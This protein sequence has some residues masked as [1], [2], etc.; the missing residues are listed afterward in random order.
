VRVMIGTVS[1]A[2]FA[3]IVLTQ[4]TSRREADIVVTSF[5]QVKIWGRSGNFVRQRVYT[6]Q[7]LFSL[8]R[9]RELG[10]NDEPVAMKN[11]LVPGCRYTV[12]LS[13]EPKN[14]STEAFGIR[15]V[16]KG[17]TEIDQGTISR[18]LSTKGC[19]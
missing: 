18:V 7:G 2:A 10:W 16:W 6:D 8:P 12:L 14:L 15:W 1:I 3:A 19:K 9:D 4:A 11:K 17:T 5:D 13:H